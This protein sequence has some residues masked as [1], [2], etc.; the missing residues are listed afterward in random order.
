MLALGSKKYFVLKYAIPGKGGIHSFSGLL[1]ENRISLKLRITKQ[2]KANNVDPDE[3]IHNAHNEH[4][5]Q[6][7]HC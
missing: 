4:P 2:F 7:L 6:V 5:L 1:S 3:G